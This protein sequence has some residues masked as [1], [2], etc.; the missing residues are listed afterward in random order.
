VS[1]QQI[2]Q[3]EVQ[4]CIK[5]IQQHTGQHIRVDRVEFSPRMFRTWGCASLKTYNGQ[6]KFCI[7]LASKI[8][9]EDSQAFRNTIAHEVAHLA[10]FQIYNQWGHGRTWKSIMQMLGQEGNRLVTK[11]E[12]TEV[13]VVVTKRKQVR[14]VYNCSCNKEHHVS[15]IVHSRIQKG[16]TYKCRQCRTY[17]QFANQKKAA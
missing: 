1:L 6:R 9:V 16:Y 7:K 14:Y 12:L 11:E 13:N 3:E 5:V 10:D 15:G 17:I 4:R 8:F 2:A